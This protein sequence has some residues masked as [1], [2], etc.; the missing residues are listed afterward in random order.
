[1]RIIPVLDILNGLA[2]HAKHGER[3]KYRVLKS[4]LCKSADPVS[5]AM[6]YKTF[7][8]FRELYIADLDAIMFEKPNLPLITR[9]KKATGMKIMADIGVNTSEKAR[10]A[11]KTGISK[12]IVG[13][14]TLHEI[15]ELEEIVQNVGGSNISVS[16]D[17]MNDKVLSKGAKLKRTKPAD[18]AKKIEQTGIKELIIL[19]LSRVGSEIGI[20]I[21]TVREITR[22]VNINILV[23]GGVRNTYDILNLRKIGINGVLVATAI[24]K[25]HLTPEDIKTL[26]FIE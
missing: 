10:E 18:L 19:E 20:N 24:H 3:E 25:G 21:K 26:S 13:T 8:G 1:M 14:E 15:E 12:L 7:F 17:L 4:L 16:L 11:L 23:G 22:K 2:V 5:V 6:A 9:I